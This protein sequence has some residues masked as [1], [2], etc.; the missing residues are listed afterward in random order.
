MSLIK[1]PCILVANV[2]LHYAFTPPSVA[3]KSEQLPIVT[4]WDWYVSVA[5][6]VMKARRV[7]L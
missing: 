6:H 4:F 7:C 3:V 5:V 2:G 1:L